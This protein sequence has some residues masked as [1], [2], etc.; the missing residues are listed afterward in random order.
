MIMQKRRR[1]RISASKT[2]ER[3]A[4]YQKMKE[5]VEELEKKQRAADAAEL[6]PVKKEGSKTRI[7]SYQGKIKKSPQ[8]KK[9]PSPKSIRRKHVQAKNAPG[10]K[11]LFCRHCKKELAEDS[12]ALHMLDEHFS[13]IEMED[14]MLVQKLSKNPNYVAPSKKRKTKSKKRKSDPIQS[15][16]SFTSGSGFDNRAEERRLD[17]SPRL[18][19]REHGRFGSPSMHD[20][21]GDES[22]P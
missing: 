20:D 10:N 11:G 7:A 8:G 4:Q 5:G 3:E 17:G 18:E 12:W 14:K 9:V 1:P 13:K 6:N 19:F 21:Y 16:R 15:S 22:H 2:R